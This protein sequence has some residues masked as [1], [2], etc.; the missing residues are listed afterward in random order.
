MVARHGLTKDL[1]RKIETFKMWLYRRILRISYRDRITNQEVLARM[2]TKPSF[3]EKI[4]KT[5]VRYAGH[6]MRGSSGRLTLNILEEHINGGRPRRSCMD[7]IK[8]WMRENC[9]C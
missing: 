3:L 8:D 9:N 5:K 6:V 4:A 2:E 7:D 1:K